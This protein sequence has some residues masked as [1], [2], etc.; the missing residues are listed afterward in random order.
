MIKSYS[1][2]YKRAKE[3][4]RLPSLF[5]KVKVELRSYRVES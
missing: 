5:L 4:E 2:G 3:G 1:R